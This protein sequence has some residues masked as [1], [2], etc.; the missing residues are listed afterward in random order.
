MAGAPAALL[1]ALQGRP[2]E[3]PLRAPLLAALA[4]EVE[5]LEVSDFLSDAGK[6]SRILAG[7]A[8]S[9]PIDVLVLDSGS[10][11][12][13]QAAGVDSRFDPARGGA[14]VILDLLKRARAVVPDSVSLAVTLTGPCALGL[15]MATQ[16]VL[17]AARAVAEAGAG[18]VIVREEGGAEVDCA[19]YS[20]ATAPLWRSLQFFRSVGVLHVVGRADAW[21]DV[22]AGAGP[23]LPV[24]SA[25]DSPAVAEAVAGAGRAYGLALSASVGGSSA[26]PLA[27]DRCALLTHDH[28]LAGRVAVRDA[29]DVVAAMSI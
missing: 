21:A 22:L 5:E 15:P 20:A 12:D 25:R 1:A 16:F 29:A 7:L 11:W 6:R 2:I 14:P 10:G 18:V 28:D 24:F 23:F 8:S 13:A 4:A 3:R 27:P 26:G 17:A 19:A 9:M